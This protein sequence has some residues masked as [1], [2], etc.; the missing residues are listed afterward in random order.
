MHSSMHW[1]RLISKFRLID[2][3]GL[4]DTDLTPERKAAASILH[5]PD[6]D[7][8]Q[9]VVLFELSKAS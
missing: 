6:L 4:F 3:M 2:T 8:D 1:S 9:K 5:V 7:E